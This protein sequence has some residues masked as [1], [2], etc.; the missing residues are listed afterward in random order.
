MCIG[1][2][3][4]ASACTPS[5]YCTV[6]PSHQITAYCTY[7][8]SSLICCLCEL[9]NLGVMHVAAILDVRTK[10]MF[11]LGHAA[12]AY[13][14]EWSE[15][16]DRGFELPPR[17]MH[18]EVHCSDESVESTRAW[19]ATRTERCMWHVDVKGYNE[20]FKKPGYQAE[21]GPSPPGLFLFPIS[22][23]LHDTFPLLQAVR[24]DCKQSLAITVPYQSR[25]ALDVGCGSGR[26]SII[27]AAAGYTTTGIDRDSRAL[28]RWWQLALRHGFSKRCVAI[29]ADIVDAGDLPRVLQQKTSASRASGIHDISELQYDLISVC[30]HVHRPLEELADLLAPNGLLLIHTFMEGNDHPTNKSCTLAYGELLRAFQSYEK[31]SA[32]H[33][34]RMV[35]ERDDVQPIE[36]GRLLSYFVARKCVTL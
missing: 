29:S 11:E 13:N 1:S 34:S 16:K 18:F 2:L 5:T 12:N 30:R 19:F 6:V 32:G 31:R 28:Q 7:L 15:M 24:D 26:D 35:I 21:V 3:P 22:P 17:N 8:S 25:Q 20:I 33:V 4:I 14:I 9:G 10:E 36:D 23:L 27:L